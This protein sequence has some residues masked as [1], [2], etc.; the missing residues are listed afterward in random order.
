MT[1]LDISEWCCGGALESIKRHEKS[2][3]Y[4]G[5][6]F[7]NNFLIQFIKPKDAR[8]F[9]AFAKSSKG[10]LHHLTENEAKIAIEWSPYQQ[11]A[12][13]SAFATTVDALGNPARRVLVF[14]GYPVEAVSKDELIQRFR[15]LGG[16][17]FQAHT[18]LSFEICP[19]NGEAHFLFTRIEI[20]MR[21]MEFHKLRHLG[22]EF[23]S[24]SVVFGK[25]PC[26]R[27]RP[28]KQLIVPYPFP[29]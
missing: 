27:P 3:F 7:P 6:K 19:E 5:W 26:D 15:V 11:D 2:K 1:F 17:S 8:A 28:G 9:L 21:V 24:C 29:P 13:A 20:A 22:D 12:T 16:S 23:S 14:Q 10:H 4:V 25:D 18:I